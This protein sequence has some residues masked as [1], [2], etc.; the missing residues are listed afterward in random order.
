VRVVGRHAFVR[1]R[2]KS[3]GADLLFAKDGKGKWALAAVL[4]HWVN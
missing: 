3:S 2:A 4:G 1:L